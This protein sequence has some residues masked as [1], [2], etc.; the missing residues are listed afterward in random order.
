[1]E[2]TWDGWVLYTAGNG[3]KYHFNHLTHESRWALDSAEDQHAE[4]H[5]QQ[6]LRHRGS[7]IDPEEEQNRADR[8]D[9]VEAGDERD[10]DGDVSQSSVF[11]TP[12]AGVGPMV[13]STANQRAPRASGFAG[14]VSG[15]LKMAMEKVG[16]CRHDTEGGT[17]SITREWDPEVGRT[18]RKHP[19]SQRRGRGGRGQSY[20]TGGRSSSS[21]SR[22]S[23]SSS[24]SSSESSNS[25]SSSS[26]SNNS[27]SSGSSDSSTGNEHEG[28]RKNVPSTVPGHLSS[29]RD[30]ETQISLKGPTLDGKPPRHQTIDSRPSSASRRQRASEHRRGQRRSRTRRSSR[31]YY[32]RQRK[33]DA[34]RRSE[35]CSAREDG[36]VA[37]TA[38]ED[39][40][41][42]L[43]RRAVASVVKVAVRAVLGTWKGMSTAAFKAVRTWQL[44]T[45]LY[46]TGLPTVV[47][48]SSRKDFPIKT[49]RACQL[50]EEDQQQ[51]GEQEEGRAPYR[52]FT[53]PTPNL[54]P[55]QQQQRWL[56]PA[57]V[58]HTDS[59]GEQRFLRSGWA[60]GRSAE[61][62]VAAGQV[63]E[64]LRDEEG[65]IGS[66]VGGEEEKQALLDDDGG[67]EGRKGGFTS[68]SSSWRKVSV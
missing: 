7:A 5:F 52:S 59:V 15:A 56:S 10:D 9:A 62:A 25:S 12:Y 37:L 4:E 51:G 55:P 50:E 29:N 57:G 42:V 44:S 28:R 53:P 66:W 49:P 41:A 32:S 22:S 20:F 38:A 39:G 67:K 6:H 8:L 61:R 33:V 31:R 47:T 30:Q 3:H 63:M 1:M 54:P 35:A 16:P 68:P 2:Q 19:T 58:R 40:L 14:R 11:V 24:S 46:G 60:R 13:M 21:S 36:N 48:T 43:G 23:S 34:R 17:G 64:E 18:D 26:S 65:E 45:D 27:D